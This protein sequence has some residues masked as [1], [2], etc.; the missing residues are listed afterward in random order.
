MYLDGHEQK[1]V[2]HYCKEFLER[3]KIREARMAMYGGDDM[4]VETLPKPMDGQKRLVLV[5]HDES[6]FSA[7]NGKSTIWVDAENKPIRLKGYSR[8]VI[9]SEFICKCHGLMKLSEVQKQNHIYVPSE[10]LVMIKP[11]KNGDGYWMNQDLVNQI[12]DHALSIFQIL[13]P[14]T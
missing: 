1:D 9:V 3:M 8:S 5:T 6:C 13:H 10:T 7:N 11:G 2:I 14:V 4:M 12:Q